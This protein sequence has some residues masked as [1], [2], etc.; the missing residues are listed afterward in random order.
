MRQKIILLR[1]IINNNKLGLTDR[2]SRINFIDEDVLG[3]YL[4]AKKR[5]VNH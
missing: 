3:A 5:V 2:V 1:R 4:E